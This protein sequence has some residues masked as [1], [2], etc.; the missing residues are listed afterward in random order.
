MSVGR[1]M[2]VLYVLPVQTR[3]SK[4]RRS[5]IR[6]HAVIKAVFAYF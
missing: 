6:N 2:S 3:V 5:R 4:Q 1:Y